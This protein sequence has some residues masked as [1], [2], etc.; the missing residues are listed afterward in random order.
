MSSVFDG[1]HC[2][3]GDCVYALTPELAVGEYVHM[4]KAAMS[5][6]VSLFYSDDLLRLSDKPSPLPVGLA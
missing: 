5:M 1:I 6:F 4:E 3:W 2:R